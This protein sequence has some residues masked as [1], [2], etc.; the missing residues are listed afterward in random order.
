MKNMARDGSPSVAVIGA[1]LSG[2]AA[3]ALLAKRGFKVNVLEQAHQPGGSS[4][5]FKRGNAVFD[6]GSAMMFGF[7]P[8]GFNPHTLLFNELEEPIAV[9]EH[10]S[11]YRIH[12]AGQEIVFHAD[13]ESFLDALARL[14]P[15][16]IGD[17][18]KFYAYLQDLYDNVI[19]KDPS[20]LSPS[21][22]PFEEMLARGMRDPLTQMRILPLLFTSAATLLRRFTTSP[23]VMHFFDKLTST[24]CYT[25]MEETPAI[26]AVTMFVE[27]HRSGS[28]YIQGS[29]QVYA[30]KLEKAIEKY[31]GTMHYGSKVTAFEP[32]GRTIRAARLADGTRIEADYFIYSGT[33]WNLYQRLL[34]RHAV[35]SSLARKVAASV[36]TPASIILYATVRREAF[37]SGTGPVEMLVEDTEAL[38][39][40]EITLYIPTMDDPSLNEPGCHSVLAIGPSFRKWPTPEELASGNPRVR[41]D[42]EAAKQEE[43]LRIIEYLN[44]YFPSFRE[45]LISW[46]V[47]SP[48]T[49]ERYTLKNGGA[50]AGP[51]QMMGQELL[52]RQHASTRWSNLF[53][54]GESTTMGTGTPAVVI[55]GLSAADVILRKE[56]LPE[57]RYCNNRGCVQYLRSP[58][59]PYAAD[60]PQSA[61]NLCLW[62]EHDTCRQACPWHMDI[63]GMLRRLYSGNT[64]GA[65]RLLF[66]AGGEETSISC[67]QCRD[68]PCLRACRR[69]QV[70]GTAVPIPEILLQLQKTGTDSQQLTL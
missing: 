28:Y 3:A 27:N 11:M 58:A 39:E 47:G 5:A 30:G 21:E 34:P 44:S 12:F 1:G 17:I 49:I 18:R 14:F 57:Y 54:C 61:G 2:L 67:S 29:T 46:E 23:D 41:E 60:W 19:M 35:P 64:E 50:V 8:T 6:A 43:G 40:S 70:L 62:C 56:K 20:L 37:P 65:R 25:T 9:I 24:Y 31:G 63:R 22:I 15:R 52:R 33:V 10:A 32:E 66:H 36:P 48:V 59:P 51:R 16:E 7:G 26:M 4:G 68:Q 53:C 45:N 38:A 55:S 13:V 42:Y 69:R